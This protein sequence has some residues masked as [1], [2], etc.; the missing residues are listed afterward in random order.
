MRHFTAVIKFYPQILPWKEEAIGAK[1]GIIKE[2]WFPH[3]HGRDPS[4]GLELKT[5]PQIQELRHA[6]PR[7]TQTLHRLQRRYR[8]S[9][10]TSSLG[11][12]NQSQRAPSLAIRRALAQP[13]HTFS[14]SSK[15]LN[16]LL[17]PKKSLLLG[18][19]TVSHPGPEFGVPVSQQKNLNPEGAMPKG[20]LWL[21]SC[22]LLALLD[23]GQIA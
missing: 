2:L 12:R 18:F 10:V 4:V 3:D 16:S 11:L 19:Q 22:A 23:S 1:G 6:V 5:P 21:W 15:V 20:G 9:N 13:F 14:V 7:P 8:A 17:P